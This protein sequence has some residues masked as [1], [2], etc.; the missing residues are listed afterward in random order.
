MAKTSCKIAALMSGVALLSNPVSAETLTEAFAAAYAT[1]PVL[2]TARANLRATDETVPIARAGL[3]PQVSATVT[4]SVTDTSGGVSFNGGGTIESGTASLNAT[5]VLY[6]GG[7]TYN[8][9]E[10]AIA[11]VNAARSRLTSTEQSVLLAVV[12]S[13]VDV[14]RDEEFVVLAKSNIRLI[15]EQLR[16]AQDR[17]DV[18]EVTRTDVSQAEARLAQALADLAGF[19]GALASSIQ[20]YRRVVGQF[21]GDLKA[22]P[23]LPPLP[24]GLQEA[25][26]L[27]MDNH[28]EIRAAR[29]DEASARNDIASAQGQLLPTVS[30]SASASRT[31]SS[32]SVNSGQNTAS[33]QAQIVVPLYQGGAAYAGVRQSQALQSAAV[34]AIHDTTRQIREL[35]ENAWSDLSVARSS[36]RAGRQQVRAAQLA[37]EGVREE[38]KLGARTTVDVL[39]AEQDLLDARTDLVA[40]L[41]DEYVAGY[42]LIS[43]I[44]ALTVADQGIPVEQYSPSVNYNEVN[45]KY[46]GFRRDELTEWKADHRP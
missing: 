7:Q 4:G 21:P 41:R 42:N 26:Q 36:I 29:F 8:N 24:A 1:N 46:F 35:V 16:A 22:P 27:A 31:E 15:E 2:I 37:F 14:R 11:D 30:L 6:D 18:G 13:F 25:V 40:S 33:L 43:A 5:Q 34:S 12:T 38:A 45:D 9:I 10:G 39:D 32:S 19:E 3:R 20:S 17:F 23:P 28:P 44:G